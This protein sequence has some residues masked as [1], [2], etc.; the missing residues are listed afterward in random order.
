MFMVI[1]QFMEKYLPATMNYPAQM[2][3]FIAGSDI[4]I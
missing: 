4:K 1:H 2:V 3:S